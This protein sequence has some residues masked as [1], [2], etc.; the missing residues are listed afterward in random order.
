MTADRLPPPPLRERLLRRVTESARAS[1]QF[2]TVRARGTVAQSVGEGVVA[3]SLYQ[4][5]GAAE[6]PVAAWR[7][8]E[9]RRVRVV[10]LSP[11]SRWAPDLHPG[12][13]AEWLV[14]AGTV[15]LAGEQLSPLDYH[16]APPG[17]P[18]PMLRATTTTA[19]RVLLREAPGSPQAGGQCPFTR[20]D[21]ATPWDD[22]APGIQ[23]RVLWAGN[24]EA[25]LL[26]RASAGAQVPSHGHRRDEECL[27]VEG[28]VFL[29]DVLL[30]TGDYQLAPAGTAHSGVST[31]TGA[32]IFAHGDLDVDLHGG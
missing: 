27:M 18:P 17:A 19:A 5:N 23:R 9:P 28:E 13:Q 32:L 30:R 1:R 2:F 31:D 25:A 10:E 24:G 20:A 11:G 4:T 16:W 29:D 14:L 26:Y 8:G 21:A 15:S 3:R 22:F 12:D 7:P 6:G